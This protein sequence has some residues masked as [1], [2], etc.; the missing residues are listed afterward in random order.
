M[1]RIRIKR[2]TIIVLAILSGIYLLACLAVYSFQR[3]IIFLPSRCSDPPPES[4]GI[5]EVYFSTE[6][7]QRLH[8]WWMPVDS[9]EYT[10][11]FLHGNAGCVAY[12][13]ERMKFF[14]EMGFSTLM[15]DYRGYGKSSGEILKEDDI[16][17]DGEAALRYL[18]DSLHLADH[19]LIVWGWSLG[20]AVTTHICQDKDL[21]AV[22]L[23]G[24]FHS[25]DEIAARAYPVFPVKYLLKYHFRSGE[26]ISRIQSPVF[27]VHS[28]EDM[29]IPFEQGKKLHD[30]FPGR[31][32]FLEIGGTHNRGYYDHRAEIIKGLKGFLAEIDSPAAN[33]SHK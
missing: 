30:A 3:R 26:K 33:E 19:Q 32:E 11:L 6:D 20:G 9:S 21:A 12:G 10:L 5:R 17:Q 22:V 14:R 4:L 2:V 16:Y 13:E 8:G 31:K 18:R 25:M 7:G 29:T 27:F 23:E 28:T 15:I 24:T 1:K